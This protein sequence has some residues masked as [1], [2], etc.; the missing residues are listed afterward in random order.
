MYNVIGMRKN[1]LKFNV[2]FTLIE[3]MISIGLVAILS[4]SAISLLG[5]SSRQSS[6]DTKRQ[7]D[8]NVIASAL[9]MYRNDMGTYPECPAAAATC[10]SGYITTTYLGTLPPDPLSSSGRD[11]VYKPENSAGNAC[12]ATPA[13]RCVS[14]SICAA[15]EKVTSA[16][17][18][19]PAT[20]GGTF[21]CSLK[22][23]EP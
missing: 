21:T 8:L 10:T 23:S 7:A 18:G 14:Y 6:R 11:Y 1:S 12:D 19:C 13:N 17:T 4:A 9:S 15:G 20:C 22:V 3:L 16:V 5:P 2:G